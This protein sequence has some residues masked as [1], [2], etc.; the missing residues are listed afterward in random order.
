MTPHSGLCRWRDYFEPGTR[1][2]EAGADIST[3][4]RSSPADT[5]STVITV[6]LEDYRTNVAQEQGNV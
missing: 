1:E 6:E 5:Y 3:E 2:H 4:N